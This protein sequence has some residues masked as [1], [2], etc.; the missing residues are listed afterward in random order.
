MKDSKL[1]KIL[2]KLPKKVF[3]RLGLAVNSPYFNKKQ[4]LL[5]FY[6]FLKKH[7]PL[8]QQEDITY[9]KAHYFVFPKL[10][11]NKKEIGYLMSDL[12]R[13]IEKILAIEKMEDDLVQKE[14]Y[15]LG[16]F[17]DLGLEKAFNK[18]LNDAN[19]QM[20]NHLYR[21]SI[22]YHKL[23]ALYVAENEF[24]L[25]QHRHIADQ[26]LQS[27]L[28]N[29]DL[30]YLSEKFRIAS[31]I[32]NRSNMIQS[33]YQ[34]EL[35]DELLNFVESAPALQEEPAIA[36][37]STI[38]KGL[39]E[40]EQNKDNDLKINDEKPVPIF[41]Q[42]IGLLEIQ[43]E[44]FSKKEA[45]AMFVQAI[46]Y[47]IRKSNS[48]DK[49]YVKQLLGLYRMIIEKD[50]LLEKDQLSPW[51]YMNVITTG[52]R[53][54]EFEWTEKFINEYKEYLL[55]KFK[56]NAYNYNL[57][58][59]YFNKKQYSQA[60]SLLNQVVF[61]DVYYSCESKALLL[62]IYFM[63]EELDAFYSL[64][65][66]FRL[67]IKRNK[68]ITDNIKEMYINIIRFL[69]RITRLKPG[70]KT[71]L[72]KIKQDVVETKKVLNYTWLIDQIDERL[73]QN[74]STSL[75]TKKD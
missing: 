7:F 68:L 24:F 48:G 60:I 37:Y 28:D 56:E 3:K 1:I 5:V 62:R 52:I 61:D 70:D 71:A 74:T 55:P 2:E 15:L 8:Y 34:L 72:M 14:T 65:D 26:S 33:E 22:Y 47:C 29:L 43:S 39:K 40:K 23:Y 44:Y 41:E 64:V 4:D 38:L 13:L 11:F 63:T 51:T 46:N 32:L 67:F 18:T 36:I 35:I 31:E 27:A 45:K 42:L 30:F 58:Y 9:E 59:L 69:N 12:T 6:D 49:S 57:A 66:S 16:T 21:N 54:E 20:E 25:Q 73:G 19:K 50:L 10:A 17:N 75:A 53:N